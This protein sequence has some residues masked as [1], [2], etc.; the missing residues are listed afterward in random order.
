M[1]CATYEWF[2]AREATR[3]TYN[4]DNNTESLG[5]IKNCLILKF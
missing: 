4:R 5:E 3:G 1:I 2:Y